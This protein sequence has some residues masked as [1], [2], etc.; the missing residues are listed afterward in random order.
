MLGRI[1]RDGGRSSELCSGEVGVLG[2]DLSIGVLYLISLVTI[3]LE[4]G[5][6]VSAVGDVDVT[7]RPELTAVPAVL[8]PL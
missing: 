8:D 7:E 6:K 2:T 1:S 3:G 4:I 5:A